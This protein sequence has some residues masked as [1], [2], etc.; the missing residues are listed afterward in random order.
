MYLEILKKKMNL[1]HQKIIEDIK[2]TNNRDHIYSTA[3]LQ[4]VIEKYDTSGHLILG[5]LC[6]GVDN[7]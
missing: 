7:Q 6:V 3:A 1:I 4:T 2:P 5:Q